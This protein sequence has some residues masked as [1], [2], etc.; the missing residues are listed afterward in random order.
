MKMQTTLSMRSPATMGQQQQHTT[1]LRSKDK[2]TIKNPG[3]G[4]CFHA[5]QAVWSHDLNESIPILSIHKWMGANSLSCKYS[6]YLMLAGDSIRTRLKMV[7]TVNFES[8][9]PYGPFSLVHVE[10]L[11]RKKLYSIA[12]D[13]LSNGSNRMV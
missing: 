9:E 7:P 12:P 4:M 13:Y 11:G 2:I 10:I 5:I 1:W 8:P 6:R 3:N